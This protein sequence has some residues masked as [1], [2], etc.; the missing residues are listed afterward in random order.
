[1]INVRCENHGI[2]FSKF[3]FSDERI[4]DG[5]LSLCDRETMCITLNSLYG[6]YKKC[7][8]IAHLMSFTRKS[9]VDPYP[10]YVYGMSLDE[11][12]FITSPSAEAYAAEK[13]MMPDAK[14]HPYSCSDLKNIIR[15]VYILKDIF[16]LKITH[17]VIKIEKPD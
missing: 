1:M 6:A 15:L 17:C 14:D 4:I 16:D 2:M 10:P 8:W 11:A 3:D 9:C 12:A 13:L 5:L 7:P